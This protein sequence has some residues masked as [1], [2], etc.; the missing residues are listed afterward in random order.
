MSR[1]AIRYAKAVYEFAQSNSEKV[2]QNMQTIAATLQNN[3]EIRDFLGNP[4]ISGDKKENIL[5]EV[6]KGFEKETQSLFK[7]LLTNKRFDI[8]GAVA[9]KYQEHSDDLNNIICVEVTTAS[10]LDNKL[11]ARVLA[12]AKEFT[13]KNI[14]LI[15]HLDTSIIGGY[16]LK[17]GDQQ[18][19][20]SVKNSLQKIKREI[21]VK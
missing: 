8:L 16:I 12:K 2:L 1:V 7:L 4:T 10:E 5:L 20:A 15:S 14:K 13:N 11:E 21:I 17:I 18:Y 6:F 3:Q 9:Q 19:N